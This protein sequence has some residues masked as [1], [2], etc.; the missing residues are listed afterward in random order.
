MTITGLLKLCFG[1]MCDINITAEKDRI[2]LTVKKWHPSFVVTRVIVYTVDSLNY[3]DFPDKQ[4][5]D[6]LVEI[7]QAYDI[8]LNSLM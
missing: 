3:A 5:E 8:Q 4:I 7:C 1:I 2:K 6:V